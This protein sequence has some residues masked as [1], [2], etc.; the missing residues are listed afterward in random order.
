MPAFQELTIDDYRQRFADNGEDYMLVDVRMDDEYED[1]HLPGAVNIPLPEIQSRLD[2]IPEDKPV[3]VVCR[4]QNRSEMGAM[5]LSKSGYAD[6]YMI[7]GGTQEWAQR[8]L[9]LEG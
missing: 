2:E 7:L 4:T 6:V 1:G 9:P 5:I 8:G 3:V